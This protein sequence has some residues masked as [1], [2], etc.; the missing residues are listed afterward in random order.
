[1]HQPAER[2]R[3]LSLLAI[4]LVFVMP[5]CIATNDPAIAATGVLLLALIARALYRTEMY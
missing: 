3:R 5:L 4:A 1:M 2:E